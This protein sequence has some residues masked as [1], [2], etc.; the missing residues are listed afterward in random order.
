[1][2]TVPVSARS[3]IS[4][5]EINLEADKISL[6]CE[7]KAFKKYISLCSCGAAFDILTALTF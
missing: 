2:Q 3:P 6:R 7:Y 4:F 5:R 1:M